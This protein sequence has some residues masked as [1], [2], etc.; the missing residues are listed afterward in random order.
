MG[1]FSSIIPSFIGGALS[2][3][4]GNSANK[5]N[6]ASVEATNA[7]NLAI[8]ESANEASAKSVDK[9]LEFQER[10]SNTAHQREVSDYRAAGLNP[11]LSATGG[12]GASTPA[13]ANYQ[14]G[15]AKFQPTHRTDIGTPA[16]NSAIQAYNAGIDASLKKST[17]YK[18]GIES[19][20]IQQD[21]LNR[22][23]ENLKIKQEALNLKE[24][25]PRISASTRNLDA[26]TAKK[27]E[28]SAK[29]HQETSTAKALEGTY[30]ENVRTQRAQQAQAAAQTPALKAQ[31]RNTSELT[32]L[33]RLQK[34]SEHLKNSILNSST[35]EAAQAA[36]KARN[37]HAIED[38]TY[39][40]IM[41]YIDR[42]TKA[43]TI[44][45]KK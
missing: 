17:E 13:G 39:A 30:K 45:G 44:F 2:L 40:T 22:Q 27:L 29:A 42:T 3:L 1:F 31:E 33:V 19:A 36:A 15:A 16:V 6:A 35:S 41:R 18:Q 4:G 28:E 34:M 37:E 10:L 8:Q 20:N 11:I 32:G 38:T 25:F 21:T 43:A 9:Q 14:A 12:P 26:D 24:E 23:E 5:S 7:S